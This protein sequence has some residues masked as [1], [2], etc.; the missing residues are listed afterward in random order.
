M[1]QEDGGAVLTVVRVCGRQ[2][3]HP[4]GGDQ[5]LDAVVLRELR[6]GKE[7]QALEPFATRSH[8]GLGR[9]P[10]TEQ[11]PHHHLMLSV[12]LSGVR[13]AGSVDEEGP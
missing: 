9:R 12:C 13:A 2:V 8:L 10:S 4:V 1:N 5:L 3:L 6:A 11:A 7:D